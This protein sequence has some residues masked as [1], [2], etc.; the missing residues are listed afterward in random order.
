MGGD[1]DDILLPGSNTNVDQI[2]P[3]EGNDTVN[4]A[5]A[6]SGF[7]VVDY[8]GIT[9]GITANFVGD[10]GTVAKISGTDN[11]LNAATIDG[12]VGGLAI[13]GTS[14]ND[15]LTFNLGNRDEFISIRPGGGDD[16]IT[17]GDGFNRLD[18][19][20]AASG[21]TVNVGTGLTTIDGDGGQ[22]TFSNIFEFRGTNFQ[23]IFTGS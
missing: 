9:G 11:F 12:I 10:A 3:G 17:G 2:S 1:G 21:V 18:Y 7:F 19:V 14:A 5:G 16:D 4:F 22:D 15:V 23:D 6:G 13:K 20:N 8:A